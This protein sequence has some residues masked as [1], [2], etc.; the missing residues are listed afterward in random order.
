MKQTKRILFSLVAVLLL[1]ALL[2]ASCNG[3]KSKVK[4]LT[5]HFAAAVKNNDVATIYDMYPDAKRLDHM[6]LPKSIDM[7][8]IDVEKDEQT[9]NYTAS[10]KN[11]R[12]QKLVFKPTDKETFQISDSYGLFEI[13]TI[14]SEL[15]VK[16]GVPLKK[17][18]D[19]KRGE[20]FKEDGGFVTFIKKE[21]A[22][23]TNIKLTDFNACYFWKYGMVYVEQNIRNDGDF[24]VKGKDYDVVFN[25]HDA[26]KIC[27]SSTKSKAGVDLAPGATFT[28]TFQLNGYGSAAD[29]GSLYWR[30]R[31][32]Q[33]GGKSLMDLLKKAKFT[34]TEYSEFLQQENKSASKADKV[35]VKTGK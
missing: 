11:S 26:N 22:D 20:L 33:K 14:Y 28:F 21:Y 9:G 32:N 2:L 6:K 16:T 17:L 19:L 1:A 10:I 27:A 34:G 35:K 7:A 4:E 8:D 24:A 23:L 31:F 5:G 25:F 30:V 18:S 29:N 13:D 12:E 15:A 3:E